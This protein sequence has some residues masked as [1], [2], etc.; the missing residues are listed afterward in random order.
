MADADALL[1]AGDLDGARAALFERARSAPTDIPT[2]MFLFQ[3]LAVAGEWDRARAQLET[4]AKLSPEAQ[5]LAVAYGQAIAAEAH[6]SAAFAG[7][8]PVTVLARGGAWI[9]DLARSLECAGRGDVAGAIAA[10]EAALDA[11]PDTPGLLS[12]DGAED[13]AFDWI[14]DADARFGPAI[15][16]VIAGRWGLL[17]FDAVAS[18]STAGVR[19]LRDTVWLPAE[20]ALVAGQSIAAL[21][22]VR[23]P[24]STMVADVRLRL[25]GATDWNADGHGLGQRLLMTSAGD[26]FGVLAVRRLT[27]AERP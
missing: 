15:E 16:A 7:T 18:I 24:G 13:V 12:R 4:L 20:V 8:G 3:L 22:P 1:S 19:D 5:M 23:Y 10:R 25:A 6:R 27:F 21:L 9:D 11:A 26:E 2:R 14:A 17:P